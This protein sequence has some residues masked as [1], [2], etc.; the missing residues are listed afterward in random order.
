MITGLDIAEWVK[1]IDRLLFFYS[2]RLV[3]CREEAGDFFAS[4]P[5][6]ELPDASG[7]LRTFGGFTW[8]A[9]GAFLCQYSHVEDT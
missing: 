4:N 3:D 2:V 7:L 9:C 5:R 8:I 1:V 6:L